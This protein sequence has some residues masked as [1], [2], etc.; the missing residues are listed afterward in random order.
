MGR[1][2][3]D[4]ALALVVL[5]A[6]WMGLSHAVA[7]LTGLPVPDLIGAAL[8]MLAAQW[9][10]TRHG[11]RTG[12]APTS[13]YSWRVAC[14]MLGLAICLIGGSLGLAVLLLDRA[15]VLN[16]LAAL[17]ARGSLADL[18]FPIALS[19][20]V[21]MLLPRWLFHGAAVRA[22]DDRDRRLTDRF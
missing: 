18:A 2:A 22:A 4:Y 5:H 10:G 11:R 17:A 9:T 7:L 21:Y 19:L 13:G 8:P 16:D 3:V 20:L 1:I 6:A 15:W 14:I 12:A